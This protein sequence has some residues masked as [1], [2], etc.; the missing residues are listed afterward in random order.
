MPIILKNTTYTDSFGNTSPTYT[1]NAGDKGTLTVTVSEQIRLSSLNNPLTFDPILNIVS[2]PTT[3]WLEEGFRPNDYVQVIT[4]DQLGNVKQIVQTQIDSVTALECNFTTWN[5]LIV[6]NDPFYDFSDGEIMV[7]VPTTTSAYTTVR[8]RADLEV[9]FNECLNNQQGTIS[10]LIDGESTRAVFPNAGSYAQ[11][12][13][14]TGTI[15]GNKSGGIVDAIKVTFNGLDT[16]G[17]AEYD[18]EVEFTNSGIYNQNWFTT[19]D[20]MKTF[21][22]FFFSSL[23]NEV[24][25]RTIGIVD[26]SANTGWFNEHNNIGVSNGSSVTVPITNIVYNT[27]D[28]DFTFVVDLGNTS[29]NDLAMG[30]AYISTNDSWYKNKPNN[31]AYYTNLLHTTTIQAGQTY[32]SAIGVQNSKWTLEIISINQVSN[33]AVITGKFNPNGGF[34]SNA[35]NTWQDGDRQ[36]YMWVK[37]GNINHLV[38]NNQLQFEQPVAGPLELSQNFGFLDHSQNIDTVDGDAFDFQAD[39]EDDIAFFGKFGLDYSVQDYESINLRVEAYNSITN[40]TFTL[41]QNS[42]AFS[43]FT[44]QPSTFRYIINASS[45]INSE[46][47]NTSLKRDAKIYNTGTDLGKQYEVAV[48]YPFLLNWKYW[49]SLAGVSPD[50]TP[51]ENQNWEQYDNLT[52]WSI[53]MV[54][55]LVKDGLEYVASN[56]LV[57]KQYDNEPDI[58][59]DITLRLQSDNSPVTVIPDGEQLYIE[60]THTL[61]TGDWNVEK[62]WGMLT[63]EPKE[64]APRSICSTIV[65]YDNTPNPLTPISGLLCSLTFPIPNVAILKCKFNPNLIDLSNGVKITA[66]IKQGCEAIVEQDKVTTDDIDKNTTDDIKKGTTDSNIYE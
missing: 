35:T 42:F 61:L 4:Y 65:P 19:T 43:G 57:D 32:D 34:V 48:Y 33:L 36:F 59:S 8:R 3:S 16:D 53:R 64:S 23:P 26:N 9:V 12:V 5:P 21:F 45:T 10:S 58:S 22:K 40:D 27:P 39:T 41:Q 13:V 37:V 50:F 52:N 14:N 11:G 56:T 31:Q 7:F 46:L 38:Y 47:P 63:I 49:L 54:V 66:K 28:T 51:N 30:G 55:G 60:S 18:I 62:T 29:V 25:D 20:C 24:F 6:L 15:V 44:Y 2:S 17:F 1:S